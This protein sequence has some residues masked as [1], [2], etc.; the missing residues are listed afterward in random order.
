LIVTNIFLYV[1]YLFYLR[2]GLKLLF[3]MAVQLLDHHKEATCC[4]PHHHLRQLAEAVVEEGAAVGALT[5]EASSVLCMLSSIFAEHGA[6][7]C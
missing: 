2:E 1:L 4:L 6:T 3:S 5:A 7:N